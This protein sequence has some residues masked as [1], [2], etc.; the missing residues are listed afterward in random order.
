ML[1]RAML[2]TLHLVLTTQTNSHVVHATSATALGPYK[3]VD[4]ALPPY[5]TCNHVLVN[6]TGPNKT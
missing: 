3:Y 6:G 4:T 1:M 5:A 2:V